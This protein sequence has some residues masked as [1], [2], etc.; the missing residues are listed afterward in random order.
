MQPGAVVVAHLQSPN[1]KY[2]GRLL[3]LSGAGVTLRGIHLG[4]FEDWLT[5]IAQQRQ[6]DLGLVTVFFPLHRVERLF[7]DE[8]VGEVESYAQQLERRTGQKLDDLLQGILPA[9]GNGT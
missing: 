9:K 4:S 8:Q 2:W 1:E 6:P 7:L 3:D 5:A